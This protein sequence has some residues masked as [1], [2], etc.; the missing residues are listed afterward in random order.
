MRRRRKRDSLSSVEAWQR[1][2]RKRR[3]LAADKSRD[4]DGDLAVYRELSLHGVAF[5]AL[6]TVAVN[7]SD[8]P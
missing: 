4:H 5:G 6:V 3:R 1:N 8:W 7:V 2:C